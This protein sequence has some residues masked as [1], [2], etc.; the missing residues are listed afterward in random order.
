MSR[1]EDEALFDEELL[2]A[3]FD[4]ED[5]DEPELDVAHSGSKAKTTSWK[6][7]TNSE[8]FKK[9]S[10]HIVATSSGGFRKPGPRP[11]LPMQRLG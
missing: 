6:W 5:L 4:A 1:L 10:F 11:K 8:S 7:P 3:D 9:A 2:D